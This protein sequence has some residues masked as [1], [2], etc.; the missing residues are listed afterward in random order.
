MKIGLS[1]Y[2]FF[3]FLMNCGVTSINIF[4]TVT[5][6]IIIILSSAIFQF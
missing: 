5:L 4:I 1:N 6:I 2:F 3:C